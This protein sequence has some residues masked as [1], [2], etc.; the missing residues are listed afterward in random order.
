MEGFHT[1]S[2]RIERRMKEGFRPLELDLY[3]ATIL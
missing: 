2:M 3:L 1:Q